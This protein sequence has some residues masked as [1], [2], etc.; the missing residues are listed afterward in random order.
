MLA[1]IDDPL[2][3]LLDELARRHSER[4]KVT[5]VVRA[6]WCRLGDGRRQ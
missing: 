4:A 3:S 1:V 5:V 2:L 6:G